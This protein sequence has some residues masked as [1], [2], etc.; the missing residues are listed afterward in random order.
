MRRVLRF[1]L[2]QVALTAVGP[3]A[4]V[5]RT[6]RGAAETLVSLLSAC[7]GGMTSLEEKIEQAGLKKR[8]NVNL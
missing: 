6:S 1:H 4:Q 3:S 8:L 5:K 7:V 2:Y